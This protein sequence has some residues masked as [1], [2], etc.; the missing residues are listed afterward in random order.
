MLAVDNG[1]AIGGLVLAAAALVTALVGVWRSRHDSE[2]GDLESV[3]ESFK[4]LVE[5]ERETT[6]R[7]LRFAN[8]RIQTL[9]ADVVEL[10]R[11]HEDCEMD[12]RQLI[13]RLGLG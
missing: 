2:R 3:I 9:E 4:T 6:D 5:A 7:E 11:L 12:R 10:R 1:S 8:S 13:A